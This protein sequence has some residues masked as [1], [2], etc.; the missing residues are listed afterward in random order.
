VLQEGHWDCV[1]YLLSNPVAKADPE[2]SNLRGDTPLWFAVTRAN[3][4]FTALFLESQVSPFVQ[5]Q[6]C[7]LRYFIYLPR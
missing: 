5:I 6:F 3:R 2:T 4:R 7:N 1:D